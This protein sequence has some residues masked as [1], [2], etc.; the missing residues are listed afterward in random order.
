MASPITL[1]V[2][3]G[4]ELVRTERFD[5]QVIKIGRLATAHL[6]LEDERVARL[7]SVIEVGGDGALSIVDM[8]SAAGTI[9]NGRRVSR[10]PLRPGDQITLG[11][12]RIVLAANTAM[13]LAEP[14]ETPRPPIQPAPEDPPRPAPPPE[15]EPVVPEQ[16]APARAGDAAAA[17]EGGAGVELRL[18]WGDA[19]LA[20]G[21]FARPAQPVR[22]GDGPRC[23][24]EV[25]AELLPEPE[26]P[27]LRFE[28]GE[29]RLSFGAAMTGARL[30]DGRARPLAELCERGEALPEAA[31]GVRSVTVPA[32]GFVRVELGSGLTLEAWPRTPPRAAV[33]P[34]WRQLELKFA[35]LFLL[36]LAGE[37]ALVALAVSDAKGDARGY[38]RPAPQ[39]LA[40]WVM[41]AEPPRRDPYVEKLKRAAER[42]G[43]PGER[44]ARHRGVEGQMGR[45]DAPRT[46]GRSA[47]RAVDPRSREQVRNLGL[48]AAVRGRNGQAG[49]STIFGQG[50]LGGDLQGAVGNLFGPVVADSRG[51]GG[52]GLKGAGPGGGG[53][54][55]TIGIGAVG[56]RG[57]GGG[58]A[59]YGDGVGGLGKK[60]DRAVAIATD[61]ARVLGAV[62]AELVRKVI[63]DHASQIR[64]CYE[65]QLAV[66]PR[67]AGKVSVRW[68]I[69]PD[70]RA[71]RLSVEGAE[72]TLKNGAVHDCM[73]SRIATWD[74]PKPKGGGIALI[75]YPWILRSSGGG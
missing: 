65:Q 23:A 32:R 75:K 50:G 68:Q 26:F 24:I 67:L 25:P 58:L 31:E 19:L 30:E 60:G 8:G 6:R 34:L 71:S 74:F 37:A 51:A 21:T 45:K 17:A 22:I 4:D 35:R 1:E 41:P 18:F 69:G 54:G 70:G 40:R 12:L 13:N 57:R 28:G 44:A 66:D 48:L 9:V 36:L 2:Y 5:R 64:Y 33:S 39:R 73:L 11:A 42:A 27:V 46:E 14:A 47:P 3:R 20:C 59:G 49:L 10:G 56:T 52:L 72:T 62:D 55:D 63:R 53:A 43:D 16:A 38:E 7:H 29:H 15:P 61:D